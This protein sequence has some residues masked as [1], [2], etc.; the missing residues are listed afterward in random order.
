MFWKNHIRKQE[1]EHIIRK[2][3]QKIMQQRLFIEDVKKMS[4][5]YVEIIG[6]DEVKYLQAKLIGGQEALRDLLDD[7]KQED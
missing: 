1:V 3:M 6:V 2:R 5:I 4:K 7:F